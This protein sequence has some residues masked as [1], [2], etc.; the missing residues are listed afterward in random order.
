[1]KQLIII[2][3]I[4]TFSFLNIP[5]L[6][7]QDY[8]SQQ[9]NDTIENRIRNQFKKLVDAANAADYNA[10]R[11]FFMAKSTAISE[12][13]LLTI[14]ND[15]DSICRPALKFYSDPTIQVTLNNVSVKDDYSASQSVKLITIRTDTSTGIPMSNIR[16]VSKHLHF[17]INWYNDNNTWK[18]SGFHRKLYRRTPLH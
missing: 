14:T 4:L 7:A 10:Y 2:S 6:K 1:M 12:G 15:V 8:L 11:A 5:G 13:Q 16:P 9:R 17:D 3:L 18:I